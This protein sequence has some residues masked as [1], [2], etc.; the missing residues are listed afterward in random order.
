MKHLYIIECYNKAGFPICKEYVVAST[1]AKA[2]KAL[3][4]DKSMIGWLGKMTIEYLLK[5][6]ITD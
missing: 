5:V 3:K 1:E 2:K 6:T 4:Q